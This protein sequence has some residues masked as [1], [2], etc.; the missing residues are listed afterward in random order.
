MV[1]SLKYS[2]VLSFFFLGTDSFSLG[3]VL[4]KPV[5]TLGEKKALFNEQISP[6]AYLSYALYYWPDPDNPKGRYK[7]I[8]GKKNEELRR[9]DDSG[10]MTAFLN[11]IGQLSG[12]YARKKDPKVAKRAG[13]WLRAWL[14]TPATRM[15]PHL[16]YAQIYPGSLAES[17]GGGIIDL[18]RL[19]EF[20]DAVEVFRNSAA[21]TPLEWKVLEKWLAEYKTWLLTSK[22]GLATAKNTANH[23]LFYQAQC[24]YLAAF[25]GQKKEAKE[26]LAEAFAR[27]DEHIAPDG[28]Q[29]KEVTRAEGWQ[30]S[31]YALR[32]WGYLVLLAERLGDK[33]YRYQESPQGTSIQ[34][35]VDYLLP[36]RENPKAWPWKGTKVGTPLP[37]L[38]EPKEKSL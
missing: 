26:R 35:A 30:Y 19:P 3:G 6:R 28:H 38:F 20:L 24:A 17:A 14:I 5:V 31:V 36:F 4:E 10:A 18:Y 2:L 12:E 21:L 27:L 29:P 1:A 32:A 25:L 11:A 23:Y 22:Q 13:E 37:S 15:E 33:N 7:P 16:K 34:K 9:L 8:D